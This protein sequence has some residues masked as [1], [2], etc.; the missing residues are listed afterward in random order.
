MKISL[1]MVVATTALMTFSHIVQAC[2]GDSDF[3]GAVC[4]TAATYCPAGYLEANGQNVPVNQ[5][6]A[7]YSL[8]G[9]RYGGT[10][11]QNF[12]LPNMQ[13]FSPAGQGTGPGL[14]AAAQYTTRGAESQTLT[15]A[16][17]PA[18]T[19]VT[20]LNPAAPGVTVNATATSGANAAPSASNN[21]LAAASPGAKMYAPSNSGGTAVAL[22][23]VSGGTTGATLTLANN[24]GTTPLPTI[25]PQ[26]V[27][28]AC[29]AANGIYPVNPN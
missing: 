8:V 11:G 6:Q 28:K 20:T 27:L 5:Y 7:L 13:G 3:T 16:Q 4:F 26:L 10:A 17:M 1:S 29:I 25:S 23:G 12:N 19:H 15:M 21:Q 24:G 22:A 9:N 18:H 2:E 14:T